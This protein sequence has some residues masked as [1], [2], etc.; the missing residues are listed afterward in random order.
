MTTYQS[1]LTTH[2][3][4]MFRVSTNALSAQLWYNLPGCAFNALRTQINGITA[5]FSFL[6][7]IYKLILILKQ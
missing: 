5:C 7:N 3:C 1:Q 6:N 2:S 4:V